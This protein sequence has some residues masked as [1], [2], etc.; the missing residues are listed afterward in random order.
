MKIVVFIILIC[1]IAGCGEKHELPSGILKSE[2]MQEVLWDVILAEAYTTEFIKKDSSK[3]VQTENAKLQ[4]QIFAIHKISKQEFYDS[5]NY[6]N[7]HIE[8]MKTL[9]DSITTRG[10][11]EKEK[12]LYSKPITPLRKPISLMPNSLL[13]P[14][15]LVIIPMPIPTEITVQDSTPVQNSAP[16]KNPRPVFKI[17]PKQ[18]PIR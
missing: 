6:Y 2:K 7:S 10:E 16:I 4:Q 17:N 9:L 3:N 13:T 8:L 18:G 5:Y 1:C 12:T 14:L 15:K 11:K